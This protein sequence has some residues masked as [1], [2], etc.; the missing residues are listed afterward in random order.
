MAKKQQEVKQKSSKDIK[1][2]LEEKAFGLKNKKQKAAIMKQLES[3]NL[4]ERLE[5]KEKMKKE[6]MKAYVKQVIPIGVDPKTIQCIN[7]LNK[8]CPDGDDCKFAHEVVKKVEKQSTEVVAEKAKSI[9]RFLIDALHSGEY[10][11]DWKCPFPE[12]N[13]VHRLVE[14]KEDV[15]VELTLEEYIEF[16]RQSLPAELT[17]LTEE[18]FKEWKIKKQNEEKEHARRV[19]AL[20]TGVLGIELFQTRRDLFKD[21]EEAGE[22]DY[23]ERCYSDSDESDVQSH[24][25]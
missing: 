4:K 2:E 22:E 19:K 17:P 11:S 13:D 18:R 1:K 9:C 10:K 20:S 24:V 16:S 25:E 3:L 21:D 14:M 15:Q 12:C 8:I 23:A 7:F 5:K 6:E